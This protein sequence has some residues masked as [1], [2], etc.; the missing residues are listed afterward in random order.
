MPFIILIIFSHV[1]SKLGL[2]ISG[3]KHLAHVYD[4]MATEDFFKTETVI[5]YLDTMKNMLENRYWLDSVPCC[6]VLHPIQLFRP[7]GYDDLKNCTDAAE[8]EGVYESLAME[9]CYQK[10]SIRQY[11]S[12][13]DKLVDIRQVYAAEDKL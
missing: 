3:A 13:F 5:A 8:V 1:S 2:G 9:S 10:E 11:I 12:A 6:D 4:K 7:A